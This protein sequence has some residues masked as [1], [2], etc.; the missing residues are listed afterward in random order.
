VP[1]KPSC[2]FT[3]KFAVL[4]PPFAVAETVTVVVALTG[5]V[6]TGNVALAV[7]ALTVTVEGIDEIALAPAVTAN[8]TTVSCVRSAGNETFPVVFV[9]PVRVAGE[10][11]TPEGVIAVAMKAPVLVSPFKVAERV[12]FSDDE[13]C[14]V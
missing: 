9:P 5:F 8:V 12:T 13:S 3:V 11:D 14:T 6:P 2:Y 10:K 4:V 1:R 7:F